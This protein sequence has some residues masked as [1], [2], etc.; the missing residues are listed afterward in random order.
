MSKSQ[1]LFNNN[2]KLNKYKPSVVV[3]S[4]PSSTSHKSSLHLF[5]VFFDFFCFVGL[6]SENIFSVLILLPM[7][8]MTV[9]NYFRTINVTIHYTGGLE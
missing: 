5:L 9:H 4:I 3:R 7:V 6:V 2:K 1:S 8:K